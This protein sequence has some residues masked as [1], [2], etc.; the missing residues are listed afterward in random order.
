MIAYDLTDDE[1][2]EL[3]RAHRATKDVRLAYRIN[4]VI[5]LG[6][7][8]SAASVAEAL[9]VDPDTVRNYF[10]RYKKGGLDELLRMS[11][12]GSEA[13]LDDEQLAELDAHLDETVYVSTKG[14]IKWVE[15]RWGVRYSESGMTAVL[16][17]LGYVY[18]KPKLIP[19]KADAEAQQDFLDTI[20]KDLKENNGE[21]S[22]IYF[23][24]GVHPQHNPIAGYGWIKRGKDQPLKTNTGRRR[25]HINGA[26][27][28]KS[29]E[30]EAHMDE[31]LDGISTIDLLKAIEKKHPDI[32]QI[33]V[34]CDNASY[35][36][37]KEVK[38]YLETSRIKLI[39]L[40]PYSPNLN[41][42]ERLWRFMKRDKLHNTHYP[43]F[44]EFK[45]AIEEF[46][47]TLGS[48]KDELRTLLTE[49][50][51]IISA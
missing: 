26:I 34:I 19:G 21:D 29:L 11:Y 35:Y 27:D 7:G 10:K 37:S 36:R 40:P 2:K 23:M 14:I 25:L 31:R 15:E 51:Q 24:D 38:A 39:F 9:L 48:R 42:I 16:R 30:A 1:L 6:E 32:P 8:W 18:K 41:L 20:Y 44:A 3:R 49:N 28:I 47:H 45:A 50:F 43:T 5:L 13:W 33:P 22:P 12:V 17:R 4:T 46:F